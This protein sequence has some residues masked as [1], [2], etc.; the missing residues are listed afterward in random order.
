MCNA[1]S[2]NDL[3]F[4]SI[5]SRQ[6]MSYIKR[7]YV[8]RN[9]TRIEEQDK[10]NSLFTTILISKKH[11]KSFCAMSEHAINIFSFLQNRDSAILLQHKMCDK[12]RKAIYL[13]VSKTFFTKS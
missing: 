8:T 5:S 7:L 4:K 11:Q 2:I 9:R 6:G 1:F 12:N 13:R 10:K 3:K